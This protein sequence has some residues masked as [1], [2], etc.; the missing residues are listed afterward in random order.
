[1]INK[2][3]LHFA[4]REIGQLMEDERSMNIPKNRCSEEK[5]NGTHS[6]IAPGFAVD[7]DE[8]CCFFLFQLRRFLS[9]FQFDKGYSNKIH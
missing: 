7:E 1:M 3:L 2:I 9:K 4:R 5:E 8:D 6:T